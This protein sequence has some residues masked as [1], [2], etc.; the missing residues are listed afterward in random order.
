MSNIEPMNLTD[1]ESELSLL[2]ITD[3]RRVRIIEIINVGY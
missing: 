3:T 1:G 2:A